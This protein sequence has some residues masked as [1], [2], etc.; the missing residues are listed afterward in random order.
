MLVIKGEENLNQRLK[1]AILELWKNGRTFTKDG[2]NYRINVS[3]INILS[4]V[5]LDNDLNELRDHTKYHRLTVNGPF[6]SLVTPSETQRSITVMSYNNIDSIIQSTRNTCI[7]FY[8]GIMLDRYNLTVHPDSS[9]VWDYG[10]NSFE[11]RGRYLDKMRAW[12]NPNIPVTLY[13]V[14]KRISSNGKFTPALP[15]YRVKIMKFEDAIKLLNIKDPVSLSC[16]RC[17]VSMYGDVYV[18]EKGLTCPVCIQTTYNTQIKNIIRVTLPLSEEEYAEKFLDDNQRELYAALKGEV[19][20]REL[21]YIAGNFA[22]IKS[23][24]GSEIIYTRK[25]KREELEGKKIVLLE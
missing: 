2:I 25:Y 13:N 11:I 9:I 7:A 5:A 18:A 16:N 8:C 6:T 12:Y 24:N 19:V 21:Y 22:L 3:N 23:S 17:S 4:D 15:G 20:E 1:D 10:P 14:S